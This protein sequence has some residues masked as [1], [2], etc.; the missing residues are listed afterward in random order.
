MKIGTACTVTKNALSIIH[1]KNELPDS[2]LRW[3]LLRED[4]Y[5]ECLKIQVSILV[6]SKQTLI[7]GMPQI[8]GLAY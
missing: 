7:K 6:K 2:L 1:Q 3:L 8:L 5:Y 4:T